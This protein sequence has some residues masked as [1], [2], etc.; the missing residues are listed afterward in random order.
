MNHYQ[1]L[2]LIKSPDI[3]PYF[4]WSKVFMQV[5]L[6]L[7]EHAKATNGETA[8]ESDIGV[9]FPEYRCFEKNG[10]TIA[11]LGSKLR[12]FAITQAELETLDLNRWLQRLVDYVHITSIRE[13][14]YIKGHLLVKRFRQVKNMDRITRQF[15]DKYGRDF[16]QVKA[17]K[18]VCIM[19]KYNLSEAQAQAHY[20]NPPLVTKPYIKLESLENKHGFSLEIDQ[21]LVS[22]KRAGKFSTYGLGNKDKATVPHW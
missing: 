6:A 7:V 4:I 14:P 8:V 1:E 17:Q 9:S 20:T 15:A 10:K 2:T 3:S 16:A 11:I 18:I 13:V 22:E 21:Q 5:H 19:N 12:V